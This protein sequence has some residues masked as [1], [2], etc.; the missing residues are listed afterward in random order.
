L[1]RVAA[2]CSVLQRVAACCSVLQRVAVCCSTT[3]RRWLSDTS[4]HMQCLRKCICVF[5]VD[6]SWHTWMSH[7]TY[8]NES[9]HIWEYVMA[10]TSMWHAVFEIVYLCICVGWV[11]VHIWMSDGTYVWMS[12]GTYVNE[13]WHKCMDES[14]HIYERLIHV[15]TGPTNSMTSESVR[16]CAMSHSYMSHVSLMHVCHD[17]LIHMC[18]DCSDADVIEFVAPQTHGFGLNVS[19]HIRMSE[20]WQNMNESWH[21]RHRVRGI[22]CVVALRITNT[23]VCGAW[24]ASRHFRWMQHSATHT[25]S[26]HINE[27]STHTHMRTCTRTLTSSSLWRHSP[28]ACAR[29]CIPAKT[30]PRIPH[31]PPATKR[32]R[33]EKRQ[34][35]EMQHTW[36]ETDKRDLQYVKRD[37]RKKTWKKTPKRGGKKVQTKRD[38]EYM[39]TKK[40]YDRDVEKSIQISIEETD[41]IF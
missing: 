27:S 30:P 22:T 41:K 7:G 4:G 10:H 20:S 14:G 31:M 25:W 40:R 8:M 13:S 39:K 23:C 18:H 9:W 3:W 2:C 38:A 19:W 33:K 11:M 36:E 26:W 15:W 17:S 32:K 28:Q 34:T 24:N 6:E 37:L 16:K 35:K 21:W 5:V 12:H 1:Q 29:C